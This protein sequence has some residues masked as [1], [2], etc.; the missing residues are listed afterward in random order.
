MADAMR[1]GVPY[2]TR[3]DPPPADLRLAH[4]IKSSLEERVDHQRTEHSD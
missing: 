4:P 3:L 1:D 2:K